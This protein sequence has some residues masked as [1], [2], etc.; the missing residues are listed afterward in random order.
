MSGDGPP[1]VLRRVEVELGERSY[2]VEIG[3]GTC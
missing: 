2:P 3:T 1:E